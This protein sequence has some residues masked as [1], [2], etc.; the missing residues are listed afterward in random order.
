MIVNDDPLLGEIDKQSSLMSIYLLFTI[1][2]HH[3]RSS[4][5]HNSLQCGNIFAQQH[6]TATGRCS[7]RGAINSIN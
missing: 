2:K 3:G 7:G 1:H 6:T 4:L 5:C